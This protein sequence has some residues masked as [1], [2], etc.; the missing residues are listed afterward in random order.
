M[1]GYDNTCLGN[2]YFSSK[3]VF[4]SDSWRFLYG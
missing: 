1:L 3:G 2:F 4:I